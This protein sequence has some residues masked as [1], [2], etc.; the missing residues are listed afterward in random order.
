MGRTNNEVKVICTRISALQ[1]IQISLQSQLD[2]EKDLNL[3]PVLRL[4]FQQIIQIGIGVDFKKTGGGI[5]GNRKIKIHMLRKTHLGEP[6]GNSFLY[7]V[8]HRRLG[9]TGKR[10]M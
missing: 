7:H 9:I 6:E 5:L 2:T 4:I 1:L 3:F 10:R 8:L